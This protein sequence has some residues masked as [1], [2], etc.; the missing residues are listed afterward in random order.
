MLYTILDEVIYDVNV[1][2]PTIK[3][4]ILRDLDATMII[5]VDTGRLN[6]LIK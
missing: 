3:H 2:P 5:I 6:P 1:F 4:Q